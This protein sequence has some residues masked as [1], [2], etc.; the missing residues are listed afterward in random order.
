MGHPPALP[1]CLLSGPQVNPLSPLPP[2]PRFRHPGRCLDAVISPTTTVSLRLNSTRRLGS[3]HQI[4]VDKNQARGPSLAARTRTFHAPGGD[5]QRPSDPA[6]AT[7]L[8]RPSSHAEPTPRAP[9]SPGDLQVP[10]PPRGAPSQRLCAIAPPLAFRSPVLLTRS[11]P[12][13][14]GKEP[15]PPATPFLAACGRFLELCYFL[16]YHLPFPPDRKLRGAGED[17]C[18]VCHVSRCPLHLE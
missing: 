4:K 12:R 14:P 17:R 5:V 7:C 13:A 16:A 15:L 10:L 18:V 2:H 11:C 3:S 9:H 8:V 6:P 1:A